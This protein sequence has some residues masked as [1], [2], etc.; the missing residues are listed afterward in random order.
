MMMMMMIYIY[1]YISAIGVSR[2][3][4]GH[5]GSKAKVIILRPSDQYSLNVFL[6]LSWQRSEA[7]LDVKCYL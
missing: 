6:W 4:P 7:V 1:I 3:G 2:A 5:V